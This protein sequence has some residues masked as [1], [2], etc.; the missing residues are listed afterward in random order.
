[1]RKLDPRFL[2]V[3]LVFPHL[4]LVP[5]VN[6][7]NSETLDEIYTFLIILRNRTRREKMNLHKL[8][9]HNSVS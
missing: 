2:S 8:S 5:L 7:R 3:S 6:L 1:M 9:G 4:S